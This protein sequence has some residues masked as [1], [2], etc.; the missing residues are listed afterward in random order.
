MYIQVRGHV[1]EYPK[2]QWLIRSCENHVIEL[3]S[4]SIVLLPYSNFMSS[5]PW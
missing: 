2:K 5:L 3:P 1:T 4:G